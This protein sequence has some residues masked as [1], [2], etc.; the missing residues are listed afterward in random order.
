MTDSQTVNLI[1]A[2]ALFMSAVSLTVV[3]LSAVALIGERLGW[4]EVER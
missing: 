4:W 3:V 1:L 2:L